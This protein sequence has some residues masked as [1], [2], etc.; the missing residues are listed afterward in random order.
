MAGEQTV[1]QTTQT[2]AAVQYQRDRDGLAFINTRIDQAIRKVKDRVFV[3]GREATAE[4]KV[5]ISTYT[6]AVK[7]LRE[8]EEATGLQLV[9]A[10]GRR[11]A[12]A[13]PEG[14]DENRVL[15]TNED[16]MKAAAEF[17]AAQIADLKRLE[18][19]KQ[20]V[21]AAYHSNSTTGSFAATI[22]AALRDL[23]TEA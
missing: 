18:R 11:V 23:P 3:Q 14:I 7:A 21:E 10:L 17:K 15:G 4:E 9:D 2:D 16:R 6:N 13:V 12:L 19:M 8:A 22:A 20:D 1:V 5:L